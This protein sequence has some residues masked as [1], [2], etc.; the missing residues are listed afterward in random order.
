MNKADLTAVVEGKDGFVAILSDNKTPDSPAGT[1]EKRYM[2]V[3]TINDD[4]TKGITNVVYI[5]DTVNDTAWFYNVEPL[6]FKKEARTADQQAIDALTT[7]CNDTFHAYEIKSVNGGQ[8]WAIV[9]TY[10]LDNGSF[11]QTDVIVYK[12]GT[13]PITHAPIA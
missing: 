9:T 8:K 13:S 7:Y 10:M 5:H 2:L 11:T 12:Q 1:K 6:S 3:E 4:G